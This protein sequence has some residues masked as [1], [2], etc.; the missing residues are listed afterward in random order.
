MKAL[1][2]QQ[3][4]SWLIATG[5]KT[6]ENR[7]WQTH[8]RGEL[9]IQTGIKLNTLGTA[10]MAALHIDRPEEFERGLIA[11]VDLVDCHRDEG[12]CR[13]WGM[14]SPEGQRPMWH[15]E[16]ANARPITPIPCSGQLSIF[17]VPDELLAAH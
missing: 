12:Y 17:N 2:V 11:I 3:P 16:L 6:I 1:S 15:W 7:T 14:T 9:L 4:W 10:W 8:H 13:P 5:Q